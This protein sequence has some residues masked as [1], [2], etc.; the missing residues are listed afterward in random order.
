MAIYGYIRKN[1]PIGTLKQLKKIMEFQCDEIFIEEKI[2]KEEQ[3][4]NRLLAKIKEEDQLIVYDL[5]V[6]GKKLKKFERFIEILESNKVRLKSISESLDTKNNPFFY[7]NVRLV[8][9]MEHFHTVYQTRKGI[10]DARLQGVVGGRPRISPQKVKKIRMLYEK[11][12]PL[13]KIAEVCEVSLGTV[14]KYV[15][16]INQ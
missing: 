15:Q 14:H 13:R 11:D 4:L 6:F 12:L 3:E 1:Y 5:R 2:L 16:I 9:E 7:G 8:I 10:K